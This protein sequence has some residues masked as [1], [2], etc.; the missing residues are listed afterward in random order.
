MSVPDNFVQNLKVAEINELENSTI[1][2]LLFVIS[3]HNKKLN[4]I[5]SNYHMLTLH[6]WRLR[7]WIAGTWW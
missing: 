1:T 6:F 5:H 3:L 4:E 2:N 7:G